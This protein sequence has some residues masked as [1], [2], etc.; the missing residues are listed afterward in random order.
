MKLYYPSSE[1]CLVIR[2]QDVVWKRSQ[3]GRVIYDG[4]IFSKTPF[5]GLAPINE[6]KEVLIH[7]PRYQKCA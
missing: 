4:I 5:K 2:I 3:F 1:G 6:V 7:I